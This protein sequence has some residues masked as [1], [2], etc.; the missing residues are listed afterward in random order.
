MKKFTTTLTLFLFVTLIMVFGSGISVAAAL[1]FGW[2]TPVLL[3]EKPSKVYLAWPIQISNNTDKRLIPYLD[4]VV[5]TNTGKQY[6]PL[7][8]LKIPYGDFLNIAALRSNLFPSATRRA[9][10]VFENVD[11]MAS[12]IHLYVGGLVQPTPAASKEDMAYLRITY[13]RSSTGWEWEETSVLK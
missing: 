5:V 8:T 3:K 13:K 7:S 10:A 11:P 9:I 12:V 6:S 1:D 4:I 2:G